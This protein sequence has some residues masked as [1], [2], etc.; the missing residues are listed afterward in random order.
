MALTGGGDRH[1]LRPVDHRT[2]QLGNHRGV[3]EH[4]NIMNP[5]TGFNYHFVRNKSSRVRRRMMMGY[6]IVSG[7]DPEIWGNEELDAQLARGVDSTLIT[8]DV[9]LMRIPH[10][11]LAERRQEKAE[12]A[13]NALHGAQSDYLD[14]GERMR[15]EFGDAAPQE[16]LYHRRAWHED[17]G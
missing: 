16:P 6:E 8:Q 1:A 14:K 2:N 17:I 12:L 7:S 5:Q 11:K 15:G 13:A 3:G 4:M 9:I 10:H